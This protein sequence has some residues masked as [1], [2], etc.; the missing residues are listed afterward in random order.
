MS[1]Q[2]TP[3]CTCELHGPATCPACR[4][5]WMARQQM[6]ARRQALANANTPKGAA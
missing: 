4:D 5:E 3:R 2:P 1:A 6:T